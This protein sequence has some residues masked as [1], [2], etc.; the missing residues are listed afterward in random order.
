MY[1]TILK[2]A[3]FLGLVAY[4]IFALVRLN[5][6]EQ[7]QEC[8][9]LEITID[10]TRQT[11]FLGENEVREL[12]IASKHY[13]ENELLESV[14]LAELESVLVAS[15]YINEALCFKTVEGKVA[16]HITPRIPVLHV[17][18]DNGEDFYI[19]NCGSVMPR[20]HHTID[21][22]VMTGHVDRATA[23][24]LYSPIG[25]LLNKDEFWNQQTQEIHVT[26]KGELEL[27]PRVG[28]H[29]I[30]LGDTSGLTD[31]LQRMRTFYTEGLD[32]AGWNRY[33]AID[34]RFKDQVIGIKKD[35]K[36]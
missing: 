33:K 16:M 21:L 17:L 26:P 20:G 8:T 19:D 15:P 5:R 4:L 27:T 29:T 36:K 18:N 28:D 31:K 10:D 24:S 32:R 30:L 34:L 13:P 11:G 9:G 35:K 25:V 23:G 7:G 22:P 2:V 6:N 14:D 12:L 1:K 3:V